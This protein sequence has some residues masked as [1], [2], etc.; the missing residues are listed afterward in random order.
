M[1]DSHMTARKLYITYL[2]SSLVHLIAVV[3]MSSKTTS[4]ASYQPRFTVNILHK[5]FIPHHLLKMPT[6]KMGVLSIL[7][8]RNV[9]HILFLIINLAF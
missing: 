5:F 8:V 6:F 4:L 2:E 3:K 1:P 9:Q 7:P